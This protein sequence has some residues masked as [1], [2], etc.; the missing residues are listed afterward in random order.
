ML[1]GLGKMSE[2]FHMLKNNLV[3]A[4]SSALVKV[5]LRY[6]GTPSKNESEIN[7]PADSPF[8]KKLSD[9]VEHYNAVMLVHMEPG[10]RS[11]KILENLLKL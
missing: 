6:Y 11:D 1:L 8:I 4:F 10:T 7:V 5:M 3:P 2:C 9:I